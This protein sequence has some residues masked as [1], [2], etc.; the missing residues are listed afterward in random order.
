MTKLEGRIKSECPNDE[1]RGS[2]VVDRPSGL[3]R[4]GFLS[5]AGTTPLETNPPER[6]DGPWSFGLRDSS[7]IRH[8]GFVIRH[9]GG[10]SPDFA[11]V[12]HQPLKR[13]ILIADHVRVG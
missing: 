10:A 12:V 2:R 8:S 5:D 6:H 11:D 9:S 13:L 3:R 4:L 7:L 1:M